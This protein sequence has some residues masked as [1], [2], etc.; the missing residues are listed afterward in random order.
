MQSYKHI[1]IS[2]FSQ[3]QFWCL[4]FLTLLSYSTYSQII[5]PFD[6][7]FEANQKGGI[8]MLS[9]VSVSCNSGSSCSSAVSQVPPNGTSSN[10]NFNMQYVDIDGDPSTFMSTSDSLNLDDC[11]EILWAGLYWSAEIV[12]SVPGFNDRDE[13]KLAVNSG[14]YQ[15][16]VADE[17]VDAFVGSHPS[18]HCFKDIT[19][20]VENAGIKARFTVADL[21]TEANSTNVFGGWT[22]IVVYK[23]VY[24]SMRNLTVFD[25]FGIIGGGNSLD[26]PISGFNTPLSGPVTFELGVVANEG[27]RGSTGDQLRFNGAGNNVQ[28]SDALHPATNVFNSTISYDATLTPFRIPNYNNTLGYDAAIFLPDNSTFNYIGNNTSSA[29]IRVQ[30]SFENILCRALTSA[31]DIYEPDLSASVYINDLNGGIVEPGDILE[32]TLVGKNIGSDISVNTFMV[33]TL[34]PRTAYV[35]GS[36]SIDFGP[37]TGPKTDIVGDDQA[38]YDLTTNSIKVRIGTGADQT[39]G[40]E[41]QPSSNGADSTVVKFLVSVIDDCLMFQCDSTLEHVAYIFGEGFISGNPYGNG[42]ASDLLD[43][44]GCPVEASNT[45]LIDVSGCPP[46]E[47]TYN[48]PICVGD[49]LELLASF[50]A[51]ANYEWSGP[52]GFTDNSNT[53]GV[54]DVSLLDTGVYNIQITFPG[55]DC[56]IDTFTTVEINENPIITL[57]DLQNSTCFEFDDAYISTEVIGDNSFFPPTI[58]W[59]N[60]SVQDSIWGLSPGEYIITVQE[61]LTPCVSVDTFSITEPDLL[62]SNISI[63][64]DYNGYPVACYGDSLAEVE[65]NFSGGTAPYEFIWSTGDTTAIVDSLSVGSYNVIVVD[66]NFCESNSVITIIQPDSLILDVDSSNVSCFAGEDGFIDLTVNGGVLGYS[67]LWSNGITDQDI[68]SLILG[69]YNVIVTDTNGCIDS[70]EVTLTQPIAP[71]S[72]S[73]THVDVLCFG[74]STG[75]IDLSSVGGTPPYTYFWSNGDTTEDLSDLFAGIYDVTVIDSLGCLDTLS[76]EVNEPDAPLTVV[77]SKVDVLC[78]GD[79]TGSVDATVSGGTPPYSYLWSNGAT[80]EDIS[81]IPAGNYS[82]QVTDFH[83]CSYTISTSIT[84]PTDS[85]FIELS[86]FD[87]D[88]F[89]APTGSILGNVLGGTAP[90]SYLWSNGE[91]TDDV[92]NLI[93]GIYTI[94]VTDDNNCVSSLSDTIGEPEGVLLSHNQVDVLCFGESTGSIDLSVSG[95]IAPYTYLWS[96]G[97]LTQDING[98]PAGIYDVD[99][100]DDNNCLAELQV[101]ITEPLTPILLSETHTDALCIGGDQGTIDLSVSGGTPGYSIV[102]NNNE[103]TED[104]SDLVAGIYTAQVTDDNGCIDSLSVE[105]LDPSNTM[106]LSVTETDV[107][108]FADSTGEIDLT[109]TGGA[110]PYTFSWSNGDLTEDLDSLITGNY[111]VIVQ[112]NNFCES[113][114]SGFIDQPLAPISVSDSLIHVLCNGDSTGAIFLETQGGTAPYTYSWSNGSTDEDID[115]LLAGNYMVTIVDDYACVYDTTISIL[116]PFPIDIMNVITEVSCFGGS[117]GSIDLNPGGGV[118]PYSYLWNTGDTIQD[119]DSLSFGNYT[120]QVTDDNG[121]IE[122]QTFLVD[123]PAEPVTIADTSGNISCFGGNDGFIDITVTGGNGGYTYEWSN[124]ALTEDLSDLFIGVYIVEVE[125]SKGCFA[126]DTITLT[127]PLAPL[128]LTTEMTA[129]LCFGESNGIASVE[130]SGGTAPYTY[131]W[132]N[133]ETTDTITGL[134]IGD[135]TVVVTDSLGCIDS[136]TVTVTEPPL[137]TAVADSVDVLCFGDSTGSVSV[138]AQGGILVYDYLWNTGDITSTVNGLPSG[139]YE[140]TV[141][142]TNGCTFVTNTTINQPSAPLSDTLIVT[143]NLC[144]G[145]SFGIIDATISGGTIPYSYA[146][147]NGETTEDIDSLANGSYTLT[148]TDNNLCVLVIDTVITSPTEIGVTHVQTN[149]SC[150]GGNDATIDLTV[151]GAMPP[152]SYLWNTADTT[153]DLDSLF[154]GTYDLI[155]TDSNNCEN[156]YTVTITEPL[157]P[158]ALSADSINVACF[159]DST[160]SIDLTVTGGTVAY[161]FSWSN[162]ELTEDITN[163]PTGSYQ[164]IVTD[165]NLCVD[166]LSMFIDQPAAPIALS[167]TQVDILCFGDFTGEIDLTVT[168]GTPA[169]TGYVFDWNNGLSADE[170]LTGLP[171][172]TYGVLVTDSLLCSD[173]LTVILT[174]PAA[175]IDIDFTILNVACFGDSTGDVSAVISGGTGPYSWFWNFPIADTTLFIDSLPAGGY[176]LNV[177]DSNNCTYAE[178]AVVTEPAGPLTSVYVDVQPSCFEYADGSLTLIPS[179]GTPGYSYLWNTGDTTVSIDSLTT[180]NYSVEIYDSLGCYFALDIFLDEPPELQISFDVDSLAGCSPFTVEFTNTSN[181]TADCQWDFGDGNTFSGC[182]DV[183]NTYEEGGIYSVSLTA[184]DDNGC[185]NDVTYTD[186]IT[187]Y[188]TPTA[189]MNIEP[190]VLFPETPTTEITNTSVGASM[191]VWNMGDSPQDYGFFE[192]GAYTYEPNVLDTFVVTLTAYSEEGCIDSTSGIVIFRNDPF[193]FA[194][195]S[196]TPDGNNVNEM[197][198]PVFSSPDYVDRYNLEIFN[199]WGELIFT[200]DQVTQGWNGMVDNSGNIAQDGI[201]TW[202]LSFKWYDQRTYQLTGH[203]TLVR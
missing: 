140:V 58:S 60:G 35:P 154:V 193:F 162:G 14:A 120:I 57:I 196:F 161:S 199:R 201:Y 134:P 93:A 38:E 200:T 168:G 71:I 136:A 167:A 132:S 105:I 191:Y 6:I 65:V 131:L 92:A 21:V 111:F 44:N 73:E 64:S 172:G 50:S 56:L 138:T 103:T 113:F 5:E 179:G 48:D 61:Q 119:I 24:N 46:P 165:D 124:A 102:W 118:P 164:V 115:S 143:D 86:S 49:S 15:T 80:S 70:I 27:D 173:S 68:D 171:F 123:Q 47:V 178:T 146:W 43:A 39:N 77:L 144:F 95:G 42:G 166:S 1:S 29:T 25:G 158:L 130:A 12:S 125:D 147:S 28:I 163:I 78:F 184:Y 99:V 54:G 128:S 186:F 59:S 74:D 41:V 129:V 101:T 133:G 176:V 137:L 97:E 188:Q 169:T 9:N 194:P 51:L 91:T 81:G 198:I 19:T 3:C 109:V 149:V 20:I 69:T 18:Y 53:T 112:D 10:E 192:P 183:I 190:Q 117:D 66:S 84:E 11:S 90:Y 159:G 89:G 32:Y 148:V 82:V 45:L 98:I 203:I 30:T 63:I 87:A 145:E 85:I 181:A 75:S 33:D 141:T 197:W 180:G 83:N 182:E 153:Q 155:I 26:I 34:D 36:I 187:V 127:Q 156:P 22:I 126:S 150:F 151:I 37:N 7:R 79:F 160:G 55:L 52:N 72:L 195:N 108:C 170:D 114:I 31:I 40:G 177:L 189:G 106:V 110:A 135:Y 139:F 100:F 142:D 8:T 76:T 4:L 202:K 96:T 104:V 23:N 16:L 67:Y 94:T 157:A 185:F 121:C 107:L 174:E 62:V 17:M 116:E 175:P 122:E 2:R 152:Y 13:I 88:C